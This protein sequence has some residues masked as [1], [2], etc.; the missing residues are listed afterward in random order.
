MADRLI[1]G[2][3]AV[4]EALVAGQRVREVL[5]TDGESPLARMAAQAGVRVRVVDKRTLDQL[6]QGAARQE[7]LP[8]QKCNHHQGVVAL[9]EPRPLADLEDVLEWIASTPQG[10]LT[11]GLAVDSL[12]D[13]RNLG[14]IVR[15]GDA[16]GVDFVIVPSRRAVGI[17]PT[18]AKTS[19]GAVEHVRVVQV[20]NLRQ[21]L[22]RLKKAGLWVMGLDE[23]SS[24]S[25]WE[26]D[27]R[28]PLVLVIGGEDKG[29]SRIVREECDVLIRIPMLGHVNSLNAS[30]AAAVAMYEVL[31]QRMATGIYAPDRS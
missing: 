2:K 3:N 22:V 27:F 28:V 15:T 12:Q 26:V 31:R 10:H 4:R 18:V 17:T 9:V 20:G 14:A 29:M 30:V 21:S 11:L 16:V 7:G 13:P 25:L 5:V 6:V 19:A 24:T 23:D 8:L 1:W